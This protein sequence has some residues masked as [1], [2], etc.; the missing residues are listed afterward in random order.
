MYEQDSSNSPHCHQDVADSVAKLSY[1]SVQEL[2]HYSG[3]N[4][5]PLVHRLPTPSFHHLPSHRIIQ[6]AGQVTALPSVSHQSMTVVPREAL[7]ILRKWQQEKLLIAAAIAPESRKNTAA[8]NNGKGVD[9][10]A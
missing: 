10:E 1:V 7:D 8:S 2:K 3:H 9:K 6:R 5:T 4:F